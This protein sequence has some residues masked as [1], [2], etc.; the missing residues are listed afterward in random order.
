M[1]KNANKTKNAEFFFFFKK[2]SVEYSSLQETVASISLLIKYFKKWKSYTKT[3]CTCMYNMV[4]LCRVKDRTEKHHL[5]KH[6]A[7]IIH[8]F[9]CWIKHN[10]CVFF[11]TYIILVDE[12]INEKD[13]L[14][15]N[16]NSKSTCSCRSQWTN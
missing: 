1:P 14:L 6:S 16:W 8:C 15:P 4:I 5:Y 3:H 13:C 7:L 2:K 10:S 9:Y 11:F 12:L